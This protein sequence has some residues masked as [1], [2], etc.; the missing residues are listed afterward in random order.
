MDKVLPNF[1]YNHPT[2]LYLETTLS[3][4]H[5]QLPSLSHLNHHGHKHPSLLPP[6]NP[7]PPQGEPCKQHHSYF[8]CIALSNDLNNSVLSGVDAT[9]FTWLVFFVHF[10]TL[11]S[12]VKLL[13]IKIY[14][15][16]KA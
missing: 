7:S 16:H 13:P 10:L 2:L 12:G 15:N 8:S 11:A 5:T 1:P 6:C 4:T 14:M 3:L 9:A